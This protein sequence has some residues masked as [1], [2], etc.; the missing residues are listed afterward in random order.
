MTRKLKGTV[1]FIVCTIATAALLL[2]HVGTA[3]TSSDED[4]SKYAD[5]HP[6]VK[7]CFHSCDVDL[8]TKK[9]RCHDSCNNDNDP[10]KKC[11]GV[12]DNDN[13]RNLVSQQRKECHDGCNGKHSINTCRAGCNGIRNAKFK[14]CED[15]RK[16]Q[17]PA[18][19]P[20]CLG[21]ET[22]LGIDLAKADCARCCSG[23]C[24]SRQAGDPNN[25]AHWFCK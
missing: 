3:K 14:E 22:D 7:A 15:K 6:E 8:E 19:R 24:Y 10:D 20:P 17:P 21:P 2:S 25:V 23:K 18:P 5:D 13:C 12:H 9:E 4:C 16:G 11:K 1:F